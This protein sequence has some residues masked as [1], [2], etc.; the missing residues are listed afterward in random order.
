MVVGNLSD[1]GRF[2]STVN[3]RFAQYVRPAILFEGL[4]LDTT[5]TMAL[6][7]GHNSSLQG[8]NGMGLQCR[9][10]SS[11]CS[12]T[13]G[14]GLEAKFTNHFLTHHFGGVGGIHLRDRAMV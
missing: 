11:N 12:V 9:I 10:Q 3:W 14:V 2:Q 5:V 1:N 8:G 6:I 4:L 7:I 13:L